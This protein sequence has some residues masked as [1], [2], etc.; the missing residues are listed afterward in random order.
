[1]GG[2]GPYGGGSGAS[3]PPTSFARS[4]LGNFTLIREN[5]ERVWGGGGMTGEGGGRRGET[6][7]SHHPRSVRGLRMGWGQTVGQGCVGSA[8]WGPQGGCMQGH[9]GCPAPASSSVPR[10]VAG[11]RWTPWASPTWGWGNQGMAG[12]TRTWGSSAPR[13]GNPVGLVGKELFCRGGGRVAP[14]C[15]QIYRRCWLVFRKSSSKGPQRLEKYPDEKAACL[16]GCPKV[17]GHGRGVPRITPSPLPA[18]PR[19]HRAT[20]PGDRDQQRQVHHAAAQ[21]DQEAGG[22]HRLRRRLRAYLHLRFGYGLT[23]R[24]VRCRAAGRRAATLCALQSWRPRSGTRRCRWSAWVP[25]STTSAWGSPTCWRPACSASRRVS[26][27]W[28]SVGSV[29]SAPLRPC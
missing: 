6:E 9:R 16:R 29:G 20:P 5:K 2:Y 17:S 11:D 28:G 3:P 15:P 7:R 19:R 4:M 13:R 8:R 21:G 18:R 12:T 22:G 25:D 10:M 27:A 23:P 24:A 1:M 14:L 26:A